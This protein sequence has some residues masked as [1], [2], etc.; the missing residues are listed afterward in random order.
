MN[1]EKLIELFQ[2]RSEV[3]I[4]ELTKQYGKLLQ[5]ISYNIL[6]NREDTEECVNDT[7]LAI[8]NK[9]PP[10]NPQ[11]LLAYVCKVARNQSIMRYHKNTAKKR[12]SFYD[13]SLDELENLLVS[14][15]TPEKQVELQEFQDELN[16]FLA[17][18]SLEN[19]KIF[20]LRYWY[21]ESVGEV[22]RKC[23]MKENTVSARLSRIR[24]S[25]KKHLEEAENGQK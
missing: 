17:K 14:Y 12:N 5:K 22:A 6:K 8:W 18:C 21:G 24:K 3:A 13:E 23:G 19:Q 10:E 7:Y 16:D 11:P 15:D 25:L 1:D 4:T 20:M 9:I 2:A